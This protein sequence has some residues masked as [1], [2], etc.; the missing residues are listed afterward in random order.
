[1]VQD[2]GD[3][4]SLSADWD[5]LA[6]ASR[7]PFCSPLWMLPWWRHAAPA[8]ALLRVAVVTDGAELVGVAPFF[9]E[10]TR[11][12]GVRYRILSRPGA[13]RVAPVAR[14]GW[15]RSVAPLFA[16][17]LA[18]ADPPADVVLFEA[19]PRRRPWPQLL[20]AAWPGAQPW[21]HRDRSG[22]APTLDLRGQT[23][24]Q[25]FAGRSSNF[26]QQMRRFRRQLE[27]GGALFSLARTEDEI[28]RGLRSL[29]SLHHARWEWRGGSGVLTP[30]VERMLR[31][32]A[33]T[34]A[35]D[36]RFR[37]W[38]LETRGKT[39][40][41][42]VFVC[43]GGEV[44]YWLGGFDE[45]WARYQPSL[46]TLLVAIEHAWSV[47]DERVDFGGGGHSYKYRFADGEDTLDWI[48]LVPK[49]TGYLRTRLALVPDQVRARAGAHLSDRTKQRLRARWA[50][51][52]GQSSPS[53][54]HRTR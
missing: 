12:A 45:G 17:A 33:G 8:G 39:I 1:M 2:L 31:D 53:A 49:G 19:I 7:Q 9:A 4:E 5:A 34:L 28:D 27:A 52:R 35:P 10:R 25:W 13:L 40:S 3:A 22:P 29:S 18:A 11:H 24:A 54:G 32:A 15:E 50:R 20:H 36:G 23:F 41:T 30:P 6:K 37:L 26:R 46:Q 44:A 42:H 43:A 21:L 51:A 14:P 48:T 16:R 38:S 47:G